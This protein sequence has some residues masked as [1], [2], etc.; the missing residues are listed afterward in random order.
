MLYGMRLNQTRGLP[1]FLWGMR[2]LR[3]VLADLEA[4]PARG[5][6]AGQV[7]RAGRTEA[8]PGSA[9]ASNASVPAERRGG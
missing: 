1:R 2:V 9:C 6:L 7:Y 4:H 5:F 8:P 3:R